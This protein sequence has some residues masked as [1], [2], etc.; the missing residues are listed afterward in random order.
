LVGV[1]L[2]ELGKWFEFSR[3]WLVSSFLGRFFSFHHFLFPQGRRISHLPIFVP[4]SVSFH[5]KRTFS[6]AGAFFYQTGQEVFW[7]QVSAVASTPRIFDQAGVAYLVLS[8]ELTLFHLLTPQ[9]PSRSSITFTRWIFPTPPFSPSASRWVLFLA[10]HVHFLAPSYGA[11]PPTPT[12]GQCLPPIT[13]C[14]TGNLI[15]LCSPSFAR[16]FAFHFLWAFFCFP[17]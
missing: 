17:A 5:L 3:A 1:L 16:R 11:T 8:L 10:R 14:S 15:E 2:L 4:F 12:F 13:L 7:N 6:P 9:S